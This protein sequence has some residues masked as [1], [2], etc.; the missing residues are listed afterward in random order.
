MA[1][2]RKQAIEA[3]CLGHLQTLKTLLRESQAFDHSRV[4]VLL[5]ENRGI[6]NADKSRKYD[7]EQIIQ[8]N[9]MM[10][11]AARNGHT[12]VVRYL[13]SLYPALSLS[14]EIVRE[15]IGGGST[16]V[17]D[18]LLAKDPSIIDMHFDHFPYTL[19]EAQ[20]LDD[21]TLDKGVDP[22]DPRQSFPHVA[23]V[24]LFSSPEVVDLLVRHGARLKNS[25]T[26]KATASV[27]KLDMVRHLL[28]VI[29]GDPALHAAVVNDHKKLLSFC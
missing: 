9:M 11:K 28:E 10:E 12:H 24:A 7:L 27:G 23:F 18:I 4:Q 17:Y 1:T 22:N 19:S 8:L 2:E 3:C 5:T 13:L 21:Q 15:A 14:H 29:G 20:Y 16:E 25:S 26:L 6:N